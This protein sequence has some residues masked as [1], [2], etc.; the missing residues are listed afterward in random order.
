LPPHLPV[1]Y[2]MY[3]SIR[4]KKPKRTKDKNNQKEPS[5]K[6]SNLSFDLAE[7]L[8]DGSGHIFGHQAVTGLDNGHPISGHSP[9]K[10]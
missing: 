1:I 3:E 7:F 10:K 5:S 2:G 4:Q 6:T 9:L 8:P